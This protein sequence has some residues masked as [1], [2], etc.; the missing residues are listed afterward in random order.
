MVRSFARTSSLILLIVSFLVPGWSQV[1][2]DVV[3]MKE[4]GSYPIPGSHLL[5]QQELE[6][7]KYRA[8]HPEL[9][10][11]QSLRKTAWS[12][13]VGS[14]HAWYADNLTNN[15]RYLVPSTCR[16]V[17]TNCYVFVENT[18]WGTRVTQAAV[19]SV[20]AAF[21]LRTPNNPSQ[22]IFDRCVEVFGNPPDVD[23]DPKVI[24]L[25]LDIID[26]Y[27]GTGGYVAG[28]FYSLNEFPTSSYPT[29]NVAEIYFLD[30]NPADLSNPAGLTSGMSTT[31]HEFQHMI[32]W[33]QGPGEITFVN[34]S[35]SQ[36]AQIVCGYSLYAQSYFN[37]EPNH[38]LFDWR[39]NDAVKVL[40]DYSRA[41][42]YS[43][44]LD[45][46]LGT[47]V[48]KPV[49]ARNEAGID[50]INLGLQDFGTA[51]R[52]ND[53]LETWFIANI[54]D[55]RSVDTRYGY[56]NP[57]TGVVS[58]V[59]HLD[60]NVSLTNKNVQRLAAEYISFTSG[61]DLRATFTWSH[62]SMRVKAIKTGSSPTQVVDVTSGV[63][64]HEPAFGSTVTEIQFVVMNLDPNA[65]HSF[66]YQSSG[67]GTGTVVEL[68]YDD[69]DPLGWLSLPAGDTSCVWFGAVPGGRL[70]SIRVA[71]SQAGS[72][73]GG[74]WRYTG[75]V[76]P[77]PL[78]TPLAIGRT[79]TA[80]A[81]WP[82][83]ATLDLR[84]D[85]ITTESAFAVAFANAGTSSGSPRVMVTKS[86]IPAQPKS[87]T[88][89]TTASVPNWYYLVTSTAGDSV[90]TY[91][92]R[93]YVSFGPTAVEEPVEL[94]PQD[95]V[96]EQNYPNPF[97][98]ATTIEY[99]LPRSGMVVLKV[100]DALGREVATLVD[101]QK[102]PGRHTAVWDATTAQ[103]G[104]YYYRLVTP[105]GQEAK[106]MVL[107]R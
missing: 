76:Q 95:F 47:G 32:H 101:G 16:A 98:P 63:E 10:E 65:D 92:I 22:G 79:A 17:G 52:F 78:G 93:A 50:G 72:M 102:Q 1:P 2:A 61:S 67:T 96:L 104:V 31:A 55:D 29:S 103:S 24:I 99:T 91:L 85:N 25:L 81:A 39:T 5:I 68:M 18:S 19:D 84:A 73:T 59:T 20:V 97:N 74:V 9:F 100:Y 94:L 45:E 71:F 23:G 21:D 8:Q 41:A 11:V 51:L 30:V 4:A 26:G 75:V 106:R 86:P 43:L 64:L 60:P 66:S 28:Y 42:R 12:F 82:T 54:L 69:T 46:Q 53:L 88:Y 49:V 89:R 40:N 34:E 105:E 13:T 36:A 3:G 83:W 27:T 80:T 48:F 56:V 37:G 44:Y 70:D 62:P 15:N 57:S 38:Y 87:L 90:W 33:A 58:A 107:L 7:Q 6:L 35:C 14:V 77:R